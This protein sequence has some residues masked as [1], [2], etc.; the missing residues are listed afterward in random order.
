M[1]RVFASSRWTRYAR[2]MHRIQS[3]TRSRGR[4][5]QLQLHEFVR[6]APIVLGVNERD[7]L[8]ELLPDL[9]IEPAAGEE[10][11]YRLTPGASVGAIVVDDLAIEIRPKLPI[12]RVLFLLS[13][14]LGLAK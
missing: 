4:M 10:H 3:P 5:R 8:R 2:L 6:S 14:S 13:Y 7:I 9:H 1:R 11:A 12:Q